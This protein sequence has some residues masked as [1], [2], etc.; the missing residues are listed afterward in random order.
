MSKIKLH[1]LT[2]P[3]SELAKEF[4]SAERKIIES[5]KKYYALVM[6]LKEKRKH[7]G[8]TQEKLSKLSKIPRT[9]ITKVESGSRNATLETIMRIAEALGSTIELRLV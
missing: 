4:S 6:A 5:E 2:S 1:N 3:L 7:L 9:T 8:M